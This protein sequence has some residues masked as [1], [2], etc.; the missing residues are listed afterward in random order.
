VNPFARY[1]ARIE[2][3]ESE[4]DAITLMME[5]IDEEYGVEDGREDHC[6]G[7]FS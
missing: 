6:G 3:L 2:Q 7:D 5:E 1:E 4:R